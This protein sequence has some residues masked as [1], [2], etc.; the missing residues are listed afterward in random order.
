MNA[1]AEAKRNGAASHRD[2]VYGSIR[3]RNDAKRLGGVLNVARAAGETSRGA[4]ERMR[5]RYE[6]IDVLDV[7]EEPLIVFGHANE[8]TL[9]PAMR[10]AVAFI[11]EAS[12]HG[13]VLV[14]C[15]AG[16]SRSTTVAIAYAMLSAA[17]VPGA[18]IPSFDECLATLRQTRPS[19]RPNAG[20][21]AQLR[22][23]HL[24]LTTTRSFVGEVSTP[25]H[26]STSELVVP[27][28]LRTRIR[29]VLAQLR[30][31]ATATSPFWAPLAVFAAAVQYV[32]T[33]PSERVPRR[34][35]LVLAVVYVAVHTHVT[36]HV[37]VAWLLRKV[38]SFV[39]HTHNLHADSH[40]AQL[41][42]AK[43]HVHLPTVREL[44]AKLTSIAKAYRSP[45]WA[46]GDLATVSFFMRGYA[47]PAHVRFTRERLTPRPSTTQT[48]SPS[49]WPNGKPRLRVPFD[50]DWLVPPQQGAPLPTP[51]DAVL[52]LAGIGGDTASPYVRCVSSRLAELGFA[53]C[54]LP[55]R[56]LGVSTPVPNLESVFDP[57]DDSDALDAVAHVCK[58]FRRVA[59]LG[60]SLGGVATCRLLSRHDAAL[61]LNLVGGVSVSGAFNV[62]F[63]HLPRYQDIYQEGLIVP[64]LVDGIVQRYGPLLMD[65][66]GKQGIQR[67]MD[68][69]TYRDVHERF[70]LATGVKSGSFEQYRADLESDQDTVRRPLVLVTAL[71]DPLH[72][73]EHIGLRPP[74]APMEEAKAHPSPVVVCVTDAGG[75]VAWPTSSS[76]SSAAAA[77]GEG[78]T[79]VHDVVEA[80][81]ESVFHQR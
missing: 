54:V 58:L 68:A 22:R 77:A 14:H 64:G 75:H 57:S 31:V 13:V 60:F 69:R 2:A 28:P 24:L 11:D 37:S 53:V 7:P 44:A 21:E 45:W 18:A 40:S 48:S 25:S 27:V 47:G 8:W 32:R 5:V 35:A 6:A 56:G 80:F 59:L 4:A 10:R 41:A 46:F 42:D 9:A 76:S 29:R 50:L 70:Y 20:F 43:E 51:I 73:V 1:E 62:G 74:A 49:T 30:F 15:N 79:F 65:R 17:R 55:P 19:V 71:D 16:V 33:H 78:Y 26:Q 39:P 34:L 67:L 38:G 52:V 12:R 72:H 63:I 23:L 36:D 61:P 81:C 66:I 3:T